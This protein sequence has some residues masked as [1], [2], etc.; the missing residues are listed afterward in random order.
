M[1]RC[2]QRR[3]T[4]SWTLR[5]SSGVRCSLRQPVITLAFSLPERSRV[6]VLPGVARRWPRLG[7][8]G[9]NYAEFWYPFTL[10][11]NSMRRFNTEDMLFRD[12]GVPFQFVQARPAAVPRLR[13]RCL[14]HLGASRSLA[15]AEQEPGLETAAY[16]HDPGFH[17]RLLTTRRT[18]CGPRRCGK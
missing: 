8:L 5:A 3:A 11:N 12:R 2:L 16:K 15:S 7:G 10:Q 13:P 4:G 17:F 9:L 1:T 6:A 18:P 14:H